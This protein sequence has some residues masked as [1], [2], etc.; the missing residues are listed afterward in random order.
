MSLAAGSNPPDSMEEEKREEEEEEKEEMQA[1]P[2]SSDAVEQTGEVAGS[3]A[4]EPSR[5]VEGAMTVAS[6]HTE[7]TDKLTE[8]TGERDGG[9]SAA[10]MDGPPNPTDGPAIQ[11]DKSVL[12]GGSVPP[13][14]EDDDE[15]KKPA[16]GGGNQ[17]EEADPT[18][19]EGGKAS[20]DETPEGPEP[21]S[22]AEAETSTATEVAAAEADNPYKDLEIPKPSDHGGKFP[23]WWVEFAGDNTE[24][25]KIARAIFPRRY[26]TGPVVEYA[27]VKKANKMRGKRHPYSK[28]VQDCQAQ[29]MKALEVYGHELCLLHEKE[30]NIVGK[31]RSN[32][33]ANLEGKKHAH[34]RH[35][36]CPG[37]SKNEKAPPS[38]THRQTFFCKRCFNM[39]GPKPEDIRC[40]VVADGYVVDILGEEKELLSREMP[41]KSKTGTKKEDDEVG[42]GKEG[43][44]GN[45]GGGVTTHA[46]TAV[47]QEQPDKAATAA[48]DKEKEGPSQGTQDH[49]GQ[50]ATA[51]S[52]N[53][54]EVTNQ[55][56]Q[57][58]SEMATTAASENEKEETNKAPQKKEPPK[59][60][61]QAKLFITHV[62]P[63]DCECN[64]PRD[65][66]LTSLI[67]ANNGGSGM[68]MLDIP[69]KEIFRNTLKELLAEVTAVDLFDD[70]APPGKQIFPN[71]YERNK[72]KE[73]PFDIRMYEYLPTPDHDYFNNMISQEHWHMANVRLWYWLVCRL[74]ATEDSF[75][76]YEMEGQS[77]G[78]FP[79][80]PVPDNKPSPHLRCKKGALLWGC[81][82]KPDDGKIPTR[83][84]S[85]KPAIDQAFHCDFHDKEETVLGKKQRVTVSQ[86]PKLE[87]RTKPGSFIIPLEDWR[88]IRFLCNG[89]PRVVRVPFGKILYFAGDTVHGGVTIPRSVE[90][91]VLGN[92]KGHWSYHLYWDSSLHPM[93]KDHFQL[94]MEGLAYYGRDHAYYL[95]QKEYQG[96]ML[97]ALME[98]TEQA[99]S[100]LKGGKANMKKVNAHIRRLQNIVKDSG[101]SAKQDGKRKHDEDTENNTDTEEDEEPEKKRKKTPRQSPSK[102]A[103]KAKRSRKS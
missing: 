46:A 42:S 50:S 86:N 88:E 70:D 66:K 3:V 76:I 69:H 89:K 61:A 68:V 60:K 38:K 98:H 48:S 13:E 20:Q 80:W 59:L 43:T 10:E 1:P 93:I 40:A 71:T 19:G 4:Q 65:Q 39:S 23:D 85:K 52:A 79:V 91:P 73:Y 96:P 45:E 8:P 35:K 75:P 92:L 99:A 22:G 82:E 33:Y 51:S 30:S 34:N 29:V 58:E 36:F 9:A 100:I 57:E 44:S 37:H 101:Y 97:G 81:H 26:V 25:E 6:G 67:D 84:S 78:F 2:E 7:P 54:K 64:V 90:G 12:A 41:K 17:V 62:Y 103:A 95:N 31:M 5:Q 102:A 53:Q 63:H 56:S 77:Q 94:S 15:Q 28:S 87:G 49:P 16:V 27:Y 18:A 55:G 47:I 72:I 74:S 11:E 21:K 83:G 32:H 24:P 14:S